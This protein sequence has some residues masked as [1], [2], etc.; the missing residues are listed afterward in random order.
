MAFLL[1][2]TT[3]IKASWQILNELPDTLAKSE[4]EQSPVPTPIPVPIQENPL[5]VFVPVYIEKVTA[6]DSAEKLWF[7]SVLHEDSAHQSI[8]CKESEAFR[9]I[10]RAREVI[11]KIAREQ[12]DFHPNLVEERLQNLESLKKEWISETDSAL[13]HWDKFYKKIGRE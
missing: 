8:Y 10:D 3:S 13:T 12:P 11:G 4:S 5:P 1:C 2:I 7:E 6:M 9:A